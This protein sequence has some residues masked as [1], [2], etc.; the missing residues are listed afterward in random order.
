[1]IFKRFVKIF[2]ATGTVFVFFIILLKTLVSIGNDK[3]PSYLLPLQQGFGVNELQK[4]SAETYFTRLPFLFKTCF[5][6]FINNK[7]NESKIKSECIVFLS[8]RNIPWGLNEELDLLKSDDPVFRKSSVEALQLY[9][10]NEKIFIVLADSWKK[11]QDVQVQLEM[12][13]FFCVCGKK[14][15]AT[16][17]NSANDDD[18]H[19]RI[20]SKVALYQI[21]NDSKDLALLEAEFKKSTDLDKRFLVVA[22]W[23]FLDKK[24]IPIL[25]LGK[26]A[27]DTKTKEF[28]SKHLF[29]ALHGIE[30]KK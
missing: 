9:P 22:S 29:E 26:K 13:H 7:K 3:V 27:S 20:I 14:S 19:K 28:A 17:R 18:S 16:L 30:S 10:Y 11:E 8:T 12:G 24:S 23:I 4:K 15:N 21:T 1:M 25:K 6:N 5:E 2:I